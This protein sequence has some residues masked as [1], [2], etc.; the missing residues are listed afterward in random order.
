MK[1]LQKY[2][3]IFDSLWVA[4][5]YKSAKD[6]A[7]PDLKKHAQ[8]TEEMVYA[9]KSAPAYSNVVGIA[10]KGPSQMNYF[11][12]PSAILPVSIPSMITT[13]MTSMRGK[14]STSV[15]WES[16]RR[17]GFQTKIPVVYQPRP[18]EVIPGHYQGSEIWRW[19]QTL[20]NTRAE[21]T[22][23]LLG[24]N[25]NAYF[26]KYLIKTQRNKIQIYYDS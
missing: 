13:F 11:T 19:I 20:E 6:L 18:Q 14:F 24:P 23:F 25:Y 2:G 4:S 1:Q 17:L 15:L 26:N 16:S 22:S 3:K 12:A 10:L 21:V 5:A 8:Q 9:I 7:L